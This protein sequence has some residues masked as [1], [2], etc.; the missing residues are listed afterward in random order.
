MALAIKASKPS[1]L[2][3]E[4]AGVA[5]RVAGNETMSKAGR[6]FAI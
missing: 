3:L 6:S 5:L 1:R 4:P 2:P